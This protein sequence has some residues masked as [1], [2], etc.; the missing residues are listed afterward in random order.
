MQE[1]TVVW[2]IRHIDNAAMY[3]NAEGLGEALQTV[4][5]EEKLKREDVWVGL[6]HL[7]LFPPP[8]T[9]SL[10]HTRVACSLQDRYSC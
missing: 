5:G 2:V 4:L 10:L 9:S 6:T 3:Y 8:P 7:S 1:K